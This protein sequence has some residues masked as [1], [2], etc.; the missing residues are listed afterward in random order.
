M[1]CLLALVLSFAVQPA[2]P[3]DRIARVQRWLAA[4]VHHHV[5]TFDDSAMG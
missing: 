2:A 4:V 5:G 3:P 1:T